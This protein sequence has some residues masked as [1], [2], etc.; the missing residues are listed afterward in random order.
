MRRGVSLFLLIFSI[1][2][3]L[4]VFVGGL[5]AGAKYTFPMLNIPHQKFNYVLMAAIWIFGSIVP[6]VLLGVSEI[7]S[8]LANMEEQMRLAT[9]LQNKDKDIKQFPAKLV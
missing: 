4:I 2:L 7:I 9:Y 6:S 3:F 5:Y 1:I 8:K